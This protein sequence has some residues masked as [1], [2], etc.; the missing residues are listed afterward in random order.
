MRVYSAGNIQRSLRREKSGR[1][2]AVA[3]FGHEGAALPEGCNGSELQGGDGV[4]RG[5]VGGQSGVQE[6][7]RR[8]QEVP[9]RAEL[10]VPCGRER[11]RKVH[12]QPQE[13]IRMKK[14]GRRPRFFVLTFY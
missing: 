3:G 6:G 1:A 9:G 13:V 4:L 11:V 14:R 12:V 10:V 2:Q 7:L 8:L 5:D